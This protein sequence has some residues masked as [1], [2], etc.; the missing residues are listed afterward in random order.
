MI[1]FEMSCNQANLEDRFYLITT[2]EI[3]SKYRQFVETDQ[4]WVSILAKYTNHYYFYS[5]IKNAS[6]LPL[7]PCFPRD[8][9]FWIMSQNLLHVFYFSSYSSPTLQISLKGR[10]RYL[11]WLNNNVKCIATLLLWRSTLSISYFNSFLRIIMSSSSSLFSTDLDALDLLISSLISF[12]LVVDNTLKRK[13]R[14]GSWL[15]W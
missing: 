2:L 8:E 10:P 11:L 13:S 4:L 9:L 3:S 6:S 14:S 5:L 15:F 12:S 1:L 7:P